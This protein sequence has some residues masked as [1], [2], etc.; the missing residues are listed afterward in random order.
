MSILPIVKLYTVYKEI[1]S[2]IIKA[3]I[4]DIL[5]INNTLT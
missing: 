1:F 4:F 5:Y 2:F 3:V